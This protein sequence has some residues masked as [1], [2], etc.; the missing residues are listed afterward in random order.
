MVRLQ[1]SEGGG[2]ASNHGGAEASAPPLES[3][4]RNAT[5]HLLY[6]TVGKFANEEKAL[7]PPP[8][9]ELARG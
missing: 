2:A 3:H 7:N 1:K 4:G 9:L 8:N 5:V 6:H